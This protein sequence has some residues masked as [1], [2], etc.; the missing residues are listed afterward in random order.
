MKW[1]VFVKKEMFNYLK[2]C[3]FFFVE[4][5]PIDVIKFIPFWDFVIYFIN[6]IKKILKNV[7]LFYWIMLFF[8]NNRSLFYILMIKT[9]MICQ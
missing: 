1:G 5:I 6:V 9:Y 2:K 4:I 3:Y 8:G 7:I